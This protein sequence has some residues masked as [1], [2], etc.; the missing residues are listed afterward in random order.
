L[1]SDCP[2]QANLVTDEGCGLVHKAGDVEDM[3]RQTMYLYENPELRIEM[4][5]RAKVAVVKKWNWEKT[6]VPLVEL[7]HTLAMS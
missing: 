6:T 4:G 5:T 7:Y 3:A 1:V 2:A